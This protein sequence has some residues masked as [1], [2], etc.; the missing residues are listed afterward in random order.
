MIKAEFHQFFSLFS[1]EH[2]RELLKATEHRLYSGGTPVFDEGD[3]SDAL[4]LVLDGEVELRKRTDSGSVEILARL[5]GDECFG[6]MGVLDGCGRSAAAYAVTDTRLARI[7]GAALLAALKDEPSA[8]II[9]MFH[10]ISERLRRTDSDYIAE[11]FRSGRFQQVSELSN[12]LLRYFRNPMAALADADTEPQQQ[13]QVDR[14][15]AMVESIARFS[16]SALQQ[17]KPAQISSENLQPCSA[18][19]LLSEL[20]LLNQPFLA[21]KQIVLTT[22]GGD[23]TININRSQLLNTLQ[24]FINNA[25]EADASKITVSSYWQ[26]SSLELTIQDNGKGVPE[27]I[28]NTLFAPFVTEG[29]NPAIGLGLAIAKSTVEAE[30]GTVVYQPCDKQGSTFILNIPI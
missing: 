28:R 30:G 18:S 23:E 20:A 6:E 2:R 22:N 13:I 8:T 29:K 26:P 15:T 10:S 7:A 19:E 1:E 4:Y 21:Q 25:V 17:K 27:R 9:S 12:S 14:I 3:E 5:R 24:I 16:D 11:T